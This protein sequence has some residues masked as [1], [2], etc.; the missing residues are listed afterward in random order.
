M[1]ATGLARTSVDVLRTV[2]DRR[3]DTA[4]RWRK[5][6]GVHAML[7]LA[8]TYTKHFRVGDSSL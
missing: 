5:T 1:D 7:P 8:A 4:A 2:R 6:R 3:P